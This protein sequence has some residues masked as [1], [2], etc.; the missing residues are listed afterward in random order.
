MESRKFQSKRRYFWSLVIASFLFVIVLAGSYFLSYAE[1]Q[2]VTSLQGSVAYSIFEDKLGYTLFEDNIC[3]QES[4][5]QISKDLNFQGRIIDDLEKKLGKN[6]KAVLFQKK[7]YT[8]VELEHFEFVNKINKECDSGIS[9][10]LFFYSNEAS[11]LEASENLG[12][13]LTSVYSRNPENFIIYSFDI[14]LDSDLIRKLK[15]E[16][17]IDKSPFIVVNNAEVIFDPKSIDEI[18]PYLDVFE[19]RPSLKVIYLN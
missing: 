14:N 6:S 19:E 9:T 13:L 10:I 11:D 8:L 5:E 1:L 3:I 12:R 15:L 7:F 18:E 16:Y 17:G 4:F 2:R